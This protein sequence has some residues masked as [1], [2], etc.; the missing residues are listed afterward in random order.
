MPVD[1]AVD[2]WAAT[3]AEVVTSVATDVE[4]GLTP[5]AAA[6]RLARLGPNEIPEA[7]PIAWWRRLARQF[8]D[9]LVVLLLI[10]IAISLV[11]W[12]TDEGGQI[13]IEAIV[14][15]AIVVLN[16]AIGTWQELKADAAVTALRRLGSTHTTV[17]R[18]GI[19]VR[20]PTA[21]LVVGDLLEIAEGDAI[22]ADARLVD[23]ATLEVS[24]ASLTGESQPVTKRWSERLASDTPLAERTNMVFSGT[25]VVRGRG[26]GIV[27]ATATDTEIGR[28]A[29]MLGDEPGPTPLQRQ[30]TWLGRRLGSTVIALAAIVVGAIIL[31]SDDRSFPAIVDALLVG[32]SLA[33]AAVPEGLPA[34]L[35]VVLALGVQRMARE[36]AI[37]KRLS[38]VE[39]LGSASVICTDKTGTLTRSEMTVVEIVTALGRVQMTGVGYQPI[40]H[41]EQEGRRLD[42]DRLH[43]SVVEVLTAGALVNDAGLVRTG[44][45]SWDVR[46][47]PTE[48]A[49]LVAAAKVQPDARRLPRVGEIPFSSER[50]RMTT[51]HE[52]SDRRLGAPFVM[53]MKGAPDVVLDR[54]T[55]ER[56]G[57]E[58]VPLDD[59][60]RSLLRAEVDDCADRALRTIA[61][62]ERPLRSAPDELGPDH[63]RGLCHLGIVGI[64]DPPRP[65]A[66]ASVA[67][68]HS[69]GV[70]VIMLTGDHER[71]A[72]R[73][74]ADLGIVDTPRAVSGAALD[75]LDDEGFRAV[76]AEH[77]VFARVAPDHK[78]RIVETLQ[79]DGRI[80][81]MTG[82][83][84]ND[85]P[86]LRRADI[87][88]AMGRGG[89]EVSKE[90][91]DMIL[92][93]DN[94]ATILRAVREG[95]EIFSDIRK[96]VRYLLSSNGGEVLVMF[97]GV[98]G[99]GLIGLSGAGVEQAVPLL[100]TQIL[101]INL[102]TDGALALAL[103][104]DPA[105]ER[106]MERPPRTLDDRVVDR[107]MLG[108]IALIS[109][110]AALAALAAIDLALDGGLLP[111]LL[112]DG[113]VTTARTLAFTTLVLAQIG[114]AFNARS[115]RLSVITK[116]FENRVMWLS[117]GVTI[118]LQVAVV[119]VP[120]LGRAFDTAPL[121][122]TD[123]L[124][125]AI[126][127]SGV[128]WADE[129]W[130][131]WL[132]RHGRRAVAPTV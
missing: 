132:R 4:R 44:D 69:A 114:N 77:S 75:R 29:S 116:P 70:R 80:V 15:A 54:C 41:L 100:A 99:A 11:A 24:E 113:D 109:V 64:L 89:T 62:A 19:A 17:V 120:I 16:A 28:I 107:E 45:G 106:V 3:V 6:D 131:W 49:F 108:H 61:V 81:A 127:A 60:R 130:K 47:D 123:W 78:L 52:D 110:V 119:H 76:L 35:S 58:V 50:R 67:E 90:A 84:V 124:A 72:A 32:V 101:W 31:T 8:T 126:L 88:V 10:A 20:I 59:A 95:R 118:A 129:A 83:G 121:A 43:R 65:E 73:I 91:A 85:A 25:A 115:S 71:T 94:F 66:A 34:I 112:G 51:V 96:V 117:I 2:A 98:L 104:V 33:V 92:A 105:V 5:S 14:I 97:L 128:V 122:P 18:D 82:D 42:D 12:A 63:E 111:A 102:L 53:V 48:V 23:A 7:P 125:A 22:G 46:G 39:T 26:T 56:V 36:Q 79:A 86:A 27:V 9:P 40:G 37:V 93:D 103:G 21:D 38:S 57:D 55:H 74:G 87:G 1:H 13:P 68:A 30:I